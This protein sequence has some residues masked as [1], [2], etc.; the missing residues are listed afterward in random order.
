M[1]SSWLKLLTMME[2]RRYRLSTVMLVIMTSVSIVALY[3]LRSTSLKEV[4]LQAEISELSETVAILES[5]VADYEGCR[6]PTP[7]D[8]PPLR[9]NFAN[10]RV[11]RV[12]YN[13]HFGPVYEYYIPPDRTVPP[14]EERLFEVWFSHTER[15]FNNMVGIVHNVLEAH[16]FDY[17]TQNRDEVAKEIRTAAQPLYDR[18]AFQLYEFNLWEICEV[19][20]P[21]G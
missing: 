12:S 16:S 5:Q 9:V 14:D 17:V 20:V 11:A 18:L 3:T 7:S 21:T 6:N 15:L 2:D 1:S 19:R 8:N 4:R 13:I 10:G